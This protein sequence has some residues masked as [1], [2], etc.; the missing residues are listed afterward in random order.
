MT[1]HLMSAMTDFVDSTASE[2]VF[3]NETLKKYIELINKC[4]I[5][6]QEEVESDAKRAKLDECEEERLRLA[7]QLDRTGLFTTKPDIKDIKKK[8]F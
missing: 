1:D 6:D 7:R 3:F 4:C 5:P 8:K 2:V